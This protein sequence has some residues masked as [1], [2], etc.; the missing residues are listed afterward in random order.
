MFVVSCV[1]VC[2]C[3]YVFVCWRWGYIGA[4]KSK[5][6]VSKDMHAMKMIT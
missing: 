2:V 4:G 6:I 5:K 1:C 3:V